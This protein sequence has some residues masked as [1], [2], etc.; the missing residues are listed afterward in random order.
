MA[1]PEGQETMLV[2][3][4]R[5]AQLLM[6]VEAG[7]HLQDYPTRMLPE[8]FHMSWVTEA[9]VHAEVH[10]LPP[11]FCHLHNQEASP[12]HCPTHLA[13]VEVLCC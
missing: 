6:G 9:T 2:L 13:F 1:A 4:L 3:G 11:E 12:V 8:F 10:V 7:V 5:A